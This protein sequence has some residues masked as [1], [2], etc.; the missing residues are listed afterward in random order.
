MV[1]FSA[2]YSEPKSFPTLNL[3][4]LQL[5]SAFFTLLLLFNISLSYLSFIPPSPHPLYPLSSLLSLSPPLSL[6]SLPFPIFTNTQGIGLS[7]P[8][9]QE[10]RGSGVASGMWRWDVVVVAECVE[11]WLHV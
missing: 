8:Y 5:S 1:Y 7:S 2:A 4:S 10:W 6:R 11:F 3:P 9:S